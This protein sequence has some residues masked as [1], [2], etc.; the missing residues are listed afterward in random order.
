MHFLYVISFYIKFYLQGLSYIGNTKGKVAPVLHA[1]DQLFYP[2]EKSH[3]C[4]LNRKLHVIPVG[5]VV[6]ANCLAEKQNP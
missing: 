4:S 5:T 3:W 1:S 2:H 6:V